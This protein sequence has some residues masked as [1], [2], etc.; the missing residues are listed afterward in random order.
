MSRGPLLTKAHGLCEGHAQKCAAME[1][2]RAVTTQYHIA[3]CQRH[4]TY[5]AD[6]QVAVGCHWKLIH[7]LQGQAFLDASTQVKP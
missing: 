2:N 3:A 7:V 5:L 6:L 4:C 1:R